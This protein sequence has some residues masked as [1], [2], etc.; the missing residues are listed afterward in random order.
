MGSQTIVKEVTS[1]IERN[2][3]GGNGRCY[4]FRPA[5]PADR[6]T[7]IANINAIGEE[8]IYL[9]SDRYVPTLDWENTLNG[10]T[11]NG[12]THLLAVV[13]INGSIIGHGRL[14]PGGFGHKDSHV[15]DVGM[16]LL[17]PYRGLGIGSELL[18]YLIDWAKNVGYEKMTATM[19][20]SNLRARR[21]F[22]GHN[23]REEGV[24]IQQF[25]VG[26]KYVDELLVA[27]F[28]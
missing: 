12:T 18:V 24:R 5:L 14:F 7:I 27:R 25:K 19:L 2:G 22:T 8:K 23:F 9:P 17:K 20:S 1:L 4:Q 28:L 16:A 6:K 10:S 13:E 26:D 21:M 11:L 3:G 15:I